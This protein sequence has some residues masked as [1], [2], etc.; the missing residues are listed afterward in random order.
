MLGKTGF[1]PE[2]LKSEKDSEVYDELIR[3]GNYKSI[4]EGHKNSELEKFKYNIF[5]ESFENVYIFF[6]YRNKS[7]RVIKI[8]D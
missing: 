1:Y 5:T 4:R 2:W 7:A 6:D 3:E 8:L